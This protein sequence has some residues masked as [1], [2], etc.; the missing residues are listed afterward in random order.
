MR[1]LSAVVGVLFILSGCH[2]S[3][4]PGPDLARTYSVRGKVLLV[5]LGPL[6][7]GVIYFSPM[8]V[9][10]EEGKIRY[11]AAGLIDAHGLYHLGF[12]GDQSGAAAGEYKVRI[13]PRDYQELPGSNSKRIPQPYRDRRH[14]PLLVTVKEGA[15]VFNFELKK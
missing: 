8:E 7:G 6:R 2:G 10:N 15:N 4:P 5:G 3:A 13:E 11:E 12:N 9:E 14:T 1:N